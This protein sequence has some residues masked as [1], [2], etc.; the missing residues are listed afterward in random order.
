MTGKV[1]NKGKKNE[2]KEN[3]AISGISGTNQRARCGNVQATRV[4]HYTDTGC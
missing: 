4:V 1:A 2:A 3:V